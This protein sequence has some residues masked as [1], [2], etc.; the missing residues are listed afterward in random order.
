MI[1]LLNTYQGRTTR[2]ST[3]C[4]GGLRS[5]PQPLLR[6]LRWEMHE[7]EDDRRLVEMIAK[8]KAA[9]GWSVANGLVVYSGH[10]FVPTASSLWSAI[11]AIAHGAGPKGIHKT[12]HRLRTSF[13]NANTAKFVKDYVRS[14][15]VC[16]RNK[17]KHLHPA[18]LLQPL[19]LPS[20]VWAD[21]AMDFM[22]GFPRVGGKSMVLAVVGRFSMYTHFILLGHPYIVVSVT[23]V[24]DKIFKLHGVLWS[25]ISDHDPV[26]TNTFWSELFRLYVV[27]LR[28]STAFHMQTDSQSKVTNQI[29]GVYLRYLA[30]D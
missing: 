13:Y 19:E 10:I 16:L 11:L 25:I 23:K 2:S 9:A 12:L 3:P 24:F 4:L 21:I 1:S 27:E 14:C 5:P 17:S 26:F 20:L 6:R 30:S 28:M 18:G 15:V 8:G 7:L 29:L 22:Q